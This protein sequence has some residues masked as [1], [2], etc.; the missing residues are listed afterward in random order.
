MSRVRTQVSARRPMG[1]PTAAYINVNAVPINPSCASS[2]LNSLRI[3]SPSTP[4]SWRSKKLSKLTAKS[5]SNA[6]FA[7]PCFCSVFTAPRPLRLHHFEQP[8]RAH[9]TADAHRDHHVARTEALARD[10]CM[11]REPLP[12]H[13]ERMSDGDRAT[14]D[15]ESIVGNTQPIAAI[16]HLHGKGFVELPE[17]DVL[18]REPCAFE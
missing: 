6:F 10:E 18:H 5:S 16:K 3:G 15:V 9:A 8:R 1:K 13:A 14:V 11:T 12:A 4:G 2:R 17:T 7:F